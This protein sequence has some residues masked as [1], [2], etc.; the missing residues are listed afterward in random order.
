[1]IRNSEH[2]NEH[3]STNKNAD[4]WNDMFRFINIVNNNT[5][6]TLVNPTYIGV[7]QRKCP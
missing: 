1:M 5:E 3:K 4:I 7:M 6:S 2:N